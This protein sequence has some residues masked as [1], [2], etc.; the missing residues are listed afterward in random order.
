MDRTGKIAVAIAIVTLVAWQIYFGRA[1]HAQPPKPQAAAA[2]ATAA[3]SATAEPLASASATP[4]PAPAQETSA[5]ENIVKASV[6]SVEYDFTNLGGGIAK[7]VLLKHTA[8]AEKRVTINEHGSFPIGA[9]S[10]LAGSDANA[11]YTVTSNAASGE[12]LCARTTAQQIEIAKKFTLPKSEKDVGEYLV[13][14]EL[15]YTNR[16]DKPY[17]SDGYF[18]YLGSATPI[19]ERDMPMYTGFDWYRKGKAHEINVTWFAAS[20]IP[21]V[22]VQRS[23]EKSVHEEKGDDITWAGVKNQYFTT[24]LSAAEKRG[25]SVWSRR[26]ALD[27]GEKPHYGIEGALGMP[28]FKLEPGETFRQQFNIYAGPKEYRVLTKLGNDEDEIMHFGLFKVVSEFLLTSMNWLKG[29]L[30]NYAAAIIVLTLCIKTLMWPLQNKATSSMKKMQALQPKMTELREKYKDDPTRMNQE[31][32]KLYKDY[33]VSPFSGCLPMFIQIPIFFGFYS[34]LGTAFELRNSKF[35]W[36]K[37]LSQPDTVAHLAGLPVNVLPICMA[38]TMLWQMSLTPKTGDAV[39]QRM[40]MF[41]PLIF[42]FFC[43]NFA[44]ALALYW[45][46]QNIFTI[47]Q[48]YVTRNKTAPVLKKVSAK[49]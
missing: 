36:V 33:G 31:L 7:A 23:A 47:V 35:L 17:Q 32:M 34:M 5:A 12:V 1:Y 4:R 21:V 39:Q 41:M 22:G 25:T 48:L 10:D 49:R 18:I 24:I 13:R 44:S 16:G 42:I 19:H 30:G 3:P 45:T 28:G 6:P 11:V 46:V 29:V 40:M 2:V 27:A 38:G 26:F 8:E 9:V 37:D 43:Y 15:S 20:Y 14:L